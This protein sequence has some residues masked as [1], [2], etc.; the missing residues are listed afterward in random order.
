MK[1]VFVGPEHKMN[2]RLNAKTCNECVYECGNSQF[3]RQRTAREKAAP[4]K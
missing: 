2:V 3:H 4:K 1:V